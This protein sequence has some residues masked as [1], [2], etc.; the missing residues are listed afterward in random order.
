M[1]STHRATWANI[2]PP[3]VVALRNTPLLD[4]KSPDFMS[5]L[6]LSQLKGF[7]AGGAPVAPEAIAIV[8]RRLGKYIQMGYGT[9]ETVGTHQGQALS[10][11]GKNPSACKELGSTGVTMTNCQVRIEPD[12]SLT[13]ADR[14]AMHREYVKEAQAKLRRGEYAPS[15][16]CIP[17]EIWTR[18]PAMMMG[19]YTGI[20]SDE[21]D[22]VIDETNKPITEDGWY[23]SGDEGVLDSA[24][25]LWIIGRTKETFKGTCGKCPLSFCAMRIPLMPFLHSDR[26]AVK[27][28]QVAPVELDSLFVTHPAVADAAAGHT[29]EEA[30]GSDFPILFI[31]PKDD[32]LLQ[33]AAQHEKQAALARELSEWVKSKVA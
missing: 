31:Q 27:G 16:C 4:P 25:N 9:S 22:S 19:Y 20:G 29:F 1:L 7:M 8:Y 12:A 24:G 30:E 13:E 28:F 10:I 26:P 18:T 2:A 5:H 17:G 23:R 21:G 32:S 3:V 6:D 15:E 11:D 33:G 14:S